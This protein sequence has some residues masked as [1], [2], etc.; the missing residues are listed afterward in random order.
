MYRTIRSRSTRSADDSEAPASVR[1]DSIKTHL[2]IAGIDPDNANESAGSSASGLQGLVLNI[3]PN[4]QAQVQAPVAQT[5]SDSVIDTPFF[6][7]SP[8]SIED[9]DIYAEDPG[10]RDWAGKPKEPEDTDAS[11]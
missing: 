6:A 2:R 11:T 4:T 7:I 1:L 8:E 10:E 3:G 5:G 9:D